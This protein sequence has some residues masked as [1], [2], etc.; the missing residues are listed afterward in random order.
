MPTV[1]VTHHFF[2]HY[3]E[4]I[5]REL[6]N[7]HKCHYIFAADVSDPVKSGIK[8]VIFG[9]MTRFI[10]IRSFVLWNRIFFQPGLI[11]LCV[12]KDVVAIICIGNMQ[13]ATTWFAAALARMTGKRVLF[14]SHGWTDDDGVIR[15]LVRRSF[16]RLAHCLLLYGHR[17]RTIGVEKKFNP[18]N[19]YVIYNSLD[20][21]TQKKYRDAQDDVSILE[22]RTKLFENP[23]LPVIICTS[24]LIKEREI[25]RLLEASA[26]LANA[27]FPINLIIVGDGPE[28]TT[29][30]R[31]AARLGVSACFYGECYDEAA[32]AR[33]YCASDITVIPGS[34]GLT[35]IHSLTYGIPVITHNNYSKHGPEVEA[36]IPGV[37]GDL[38]RWHDTQDLVYL[39][40]KWASISKTESQK[41]KISR[42]VE[43]FY[44]P[45]IQRSIF[46]LAVTGELQDNDPWEHRATLVELIS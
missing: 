2:A 4:A 22:T 16:Y 29:W 37:N 44:H 41:R 8:P 15:D 9:D 42:I 12:R 40:R 34:A 36:I 11:S 46:D 10:R 19:L 17:A 14:W 39:I 31:L 18:N 13:F 21:D 24:R 6:I 33:L 27:E 7:S 5:V 1:V 35:V 25:D 38:Y 23:N 20:Y 30:Q 43:L 3:R 28:K 45:Q 26:L 32:L